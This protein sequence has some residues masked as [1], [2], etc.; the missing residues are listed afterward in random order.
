MPAER[1]MPAERIDRRKQKP[2][3]GKPMPLNVLRWT[4]QKARPRARVARSATRP[5]PKMAEQQQEAEQ[6]QDG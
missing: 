4:K 2:I 6:E 5:K 3:K 1:K